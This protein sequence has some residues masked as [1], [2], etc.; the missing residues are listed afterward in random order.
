MMD[1][2]MGMIA[3]ALLISFTLIMA[4]SKLTKNKLD[5]KDK[6]TITYYILFSVYLFISYMITDNFIRII[7]NYLILTH[8]YSRIYNMS[9]VKTFTVSFITVV[10]IFIAEIIFDIT[11]VTILKFDVEDIQKT[12]FVSLFA[13]ITIAIIILL[14]TKIKKLNNFCYKLISNSNIESYKI[15]IL[16]ILLSLTALALLLYYI[17]FV[18]FVYKKD[19][20]PTI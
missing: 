16:F 12:Y 13:N 15:F 8:I 18:Q 7:I 3:S 6:K 4:G 14:L 10:Y 17:Y 9:I 5:F 1:K 2:I 20:N 11:V 19:N